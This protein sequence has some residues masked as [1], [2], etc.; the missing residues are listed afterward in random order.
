MNESGKNSSMPIEIIQVRDDG[1]FGPGGS[2][3][4]GQ[5][6]EHFITEER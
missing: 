6:L 5:I 3:R 2:E 4:C 1:G